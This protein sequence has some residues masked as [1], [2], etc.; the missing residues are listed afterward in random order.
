MTEA[1]VSAG[2]QCRARRRA[3]AM[4][5]LGAALITGCAPMPGLRPA[6]TVVPVA[7][8]AS[9]VHMVCPLPV[10]HPSV[11]LLRTATEWNALM[12]MALERPLPTHWTAVDFAHEAVAVV[13]LPSAPQPP[14]RVALAEQDPVVLDGATGMVRITMVLPAPRSPLE[15]AATVVATPCAVLRVASPSPVTAVQAWQGDRLI[16]SAAVP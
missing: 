4:V 9:S 11:R 14:S 1:A 2:W 3:L 10:P 6:S 7:V 15:L 8:V 12:S 16:A 13:A 5:G